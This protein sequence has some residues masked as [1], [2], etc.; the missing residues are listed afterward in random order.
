MTQKKITRDYYQIQLDDFGLQEDPEE[1]ARIA[2]QEA[3][4]RAR[5]YAV[6]CEWQ[7]IDDDGYTVTVVRRRFA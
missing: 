6:P 4:E 7:V 2:I 1:R 5:I 3:Q